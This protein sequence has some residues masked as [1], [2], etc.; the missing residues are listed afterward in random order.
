MTLYEQIVKAVNDGKSFSADHNGMLPYVNI[1]TLPIDCPRT[2]LA[3]LGYFV[4]QWA[5]KSVHK[6]NSIISFIVSNDKIKI[7]Y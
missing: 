7:Y 2:D 6:E 5:S 3:M 4:Q 1:D